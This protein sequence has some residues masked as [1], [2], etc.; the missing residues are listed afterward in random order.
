MT[1]QIR[2]LSAVESFLKYLLAEKGYSQLTIIEYERDLNLFYRYLVKVRQLPADQIMLNSFGAFE[3]RE[4]LNDLVLL[5]NN[6]PITRNRR[7]C[8]LRSFCKFMV[9]S[10]YLTINPTDGIDSSKTEKRAEP[11]YLKLEEATKYLQSIETYGK[12]NLERDLAIVKM[13]LYGGLRVSELISL[14]VDDLDFAD[15]S[16]KFFGKGNKERYVPLHPDVIESILNYLP[17]RNQILTNDEDAK[18][19]L[20]RS[21]KGKRLGIRSV[22]LMVK[23]YAKLAGIKN[24]EK[25]TPHKL[26]HTFATML[27]QKTKDLRVLQDLLGHSNISTTQIYTHTDKED[28]KDA[29]DELPSITT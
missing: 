9:K 7:K 13:F 26:R 22:Q 25:I 20:F 15:C 28:R 2:F 24:A 3:I 11:I 8:S 16:I 21:L 18:K 27:Y 29:I 1:N 17:S 10:G 14:D 23:K 4:F 6:S 5:N 19:A 12:K